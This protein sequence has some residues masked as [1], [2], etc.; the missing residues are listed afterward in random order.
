MSKKNTG[1]LN[2]YLAPN[3]SFDMEKMK[4]SFQI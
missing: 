3:I 4:G 1:T 2:T